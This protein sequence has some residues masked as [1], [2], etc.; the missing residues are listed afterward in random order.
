MIIP[1]LSTAGSGCHSNS[2]VVLDVI[3]KDCT[4]GL[5]EGAVCVCVCLSVCECVC[6]CECVG[7]CVCVCVCI[8]Q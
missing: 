6:V 1:F 3:I 2:A 7:V 4:I 5:A 8:S